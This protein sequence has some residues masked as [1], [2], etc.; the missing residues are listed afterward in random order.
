VQGEG[1]MD[2]RPDFKNSGYD[3]SHSEDV[4]QV[5]SDMIDE[6]MRLDVSVANYSRLISSPVLVNTVK[7]YMLFEEICQKYVGRLLPVKGTTTSHKISEVN[8]LPV[9][10]PTPIHFR[11]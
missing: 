1:A 4:R 10:Q 11:I 6:L 9:V 2:T 8:I 3:S 5:V 7:A